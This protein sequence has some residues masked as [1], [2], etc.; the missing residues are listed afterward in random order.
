M[1][2]LIFGSSSE[3]TRLIA[4]KLLLDFRGPIYTFGTGPKEHSDYASFTTTYNQIAY[5]AQ[6]LDGIITNIVSRDGVRLCMI[7]HSTAQD[8]MPYVAECV[9]E[10]KI[11]SF[12][13]ATLTKVFNIDFLSVYAICNALYRYKHAQGLKIVL[14]SSHAADF[15][16]H[17]YS[18]S[19]RFASDIPLTQRYR[20]D[21]FHYVLKFQNVPSNMSNA[22]ETYDKIQADLFGGKPREVN[23]MWMKPSEF[24]HFFVNAINAPKPKFMKIC[25]YPCIAREP[26]A[27]SH[28]RRLASS[29]IPL[30]LVPWW[31]KFLLK[32]VVGID[33]HV[34]SK[35]TEEFSAPSLSAAA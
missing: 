24:Q 9:S 23:P 27:I 29:K 15:S 32:Y 4:T 10:G 8:Y 3:C 11:I 35:M 33:L 13:P 26:W 16:V 14:F 28:D 25:A 21:I 19:K 18:L 5:E 2:A 30:V 7:G 6:E 20:P 34:F 1:A 17:L 22:S 31:K 12:D